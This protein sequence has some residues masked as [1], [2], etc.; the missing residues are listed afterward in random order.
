MRSLALRMAP[1]LLERPTFFELEE[2]A[3]VYL[4][5]IMFSQGGKPRSQ[6][7]RWEMTNSGAYLTKLTKTKVVIWKLGM[8]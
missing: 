8:L 3:R 1:R 2:I 5:F 7:T 4:F 6:R